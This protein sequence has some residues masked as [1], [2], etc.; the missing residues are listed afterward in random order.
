MGLQGRGD[1]AVVSL[2]PNSVPPV[3]LEILIPLKPRG[4]QKQLLIFLPTS[5]PVREET[6]M[7]S[8]VL[9][10][11]SCM[12]LGRRAPFSLDSLQNLKKCRLIVLTV[13]NFLPSSR[14]LEL[15]GYR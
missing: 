14:L 1:L 13:K 10:S 11:K 8:H 9:E 4:D 5:F 7:P 12:H 3:Y 6:S 15:Q 2:F